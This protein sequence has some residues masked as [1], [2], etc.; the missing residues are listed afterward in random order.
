MTT[1]EKVVSMMRKAAAVRRLNDKVMAKRAEYRNMPS[2]A[3]LEGFSKAAE[4]YGV[5][6]VALLKFAAG[7]APA[8]APAAKVDPKGSAGIGTY[9]QQGGPVIVRGDSSNGRASAPGSYFG[10]LAGNYT[11]KVTPGSTKEEMVG[12]PMYR[13]ENWKDIDDT[14]AARSNNEAHS[15]FPMGNE[16][17]TNEALGD[18]RA[19]IAS[20]R[21]SE[22]F[23]EGSVPHGAVRK[24]LIDAGV[25]NHANWQRTGTVAPRT[26]P[27]GTGELQLTPEQKKKLLM[28]QNSQ[29]MLRRRAPRNVA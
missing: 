16:T 7:A 13:G 6:P 20:S 17:I 26:A 9:A 3:Y 14:P 29:A 23:P 18:M 21:A 24:S 27:E 2:D 15:R 8:A 28:Y 12:A 11:G 10:A 5:D 4:Y 25:K 22:F 19:D 1:K